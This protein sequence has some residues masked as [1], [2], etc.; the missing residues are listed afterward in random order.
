MSDSFITIIAKSPTELV[1]EGEQLHHCVGK[2]GYD[3]KFAKEQS[4]IFFIRFSYHSSFIERSSPP[5]KTNVLNPN[6]Y[7]LLQHSK[8]VS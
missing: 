5:C 3:Q 4:L 7:P 2:M 1:Y 6:S 8:I